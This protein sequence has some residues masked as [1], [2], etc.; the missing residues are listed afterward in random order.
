MSAEVWLKLLGCAI[1][2]GSL[3]GGLSYLLVLRKIDKIIRA[4]K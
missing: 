1:A 2:I 3:Y 4:R